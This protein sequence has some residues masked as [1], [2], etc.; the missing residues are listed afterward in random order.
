MPTSTNN[1]NPLSYELSDNDIE[2][3]LK[4]AQAGVVAAEDLADVS[5]ASGVR[6]LDGLGNN[7]ENPLWGNADQTFKRLSDTHFDNGVDTPRDGPVPRDISNLILNQNKDGETNNFGPNAGEDDLNLE[8]NFRANEFVWAFGQYFDHGLDFI[9]KGGENGDGTEAGTMFL[10]NF[11]TPGGDIPLTLTRATPAD[12][13]GINGVPREYINQTSP[14]ID[15]NQ[16]YGSN[17]KILEFLLERDDNGQFTGRLLSGE[18]SDIPTLGEAKANWQ[19]GVDNGLAEAIDFS[20][21]DAISNFRGSG[22]ALL[23]DINPGIPL[24][25]HLVAGDGRVN[26]NAG[27]SVVHTIWHNNHNFWVEKLAKHYDENGGGE[28]VTNE[29]LY[30]MAK[31]INE[32]EYQ[33]A[34]ADEF[35]ELLVGSDVHAFLDYNPEINADITLEFSQAAYRLG[36]SMLNNHITVRTDADGSTED[37]PL[38]DLFLNPLQFTQLGADNIA[39]GMFT[40]LQQEI[41]AQIVTT[42]RDNLLGRPLD[43]A[44]LNIGR[45]RDTG[46]PTLNDMRE[47]VGLSKYSDWD[48]F[49][50][51][52]RD[53]SQIDDFKAAYNSIDE[54]DLWVGGLA[55]KP[56]SSDAFGTE[57]AQ[58]SVMGETFAQ[59]FSTQMIALQDGDRFYYKHR[60]L[61]TELLANIQNQ[62]FADIIERTLDLEYLSADVFKV[63][64]NRLDFRDVDESQE[65]LSG[66]GKL[67]LENG[68]FE[69]EILDDGKKEGDV[70]GWESDD[71]YVFNPKDSHIDETSLTGSNMVYLKDKGWISQTLEEEYAIG[72]DYSFDVDLGSKSDDVTDDRGYVIKL[73]AGD[74]EIGRTEGSIAGINTLETVS[75]TSQG[76]NNPDL[77]GESIRIV[78]ENTGEEDLYIDNVRGS[79]GD[80]GSSKKGHDIIIG[81]DI[82]ETIFGK[83]GDDTIFAE[84]GDDEVFGGDGDDAMHGGAGDD[85]LIGEDG[86]DRADG[87]YGNDHIEGGIGDDDLSG[88]EG[89]DFV[90]GGLNDDEAFGGAGNDHVR[91]GSG[92]DE[93][94]G[95]LGDDLVDA[96]VGNDIANGSDGNDTVLGGHGNDRLMGGEG[97]DTLTGGQ[98][99]DEYWFLPESGQDVITDF[100]IGK[101]KVDLHRYVWE[102]GKNEVLTA[103]H[104]MSDNGDH[105][106]LTLPED[107]TIKFEGVSKWDLLDDARHFVLEDRVFER[108]NLILDEETSIVVDAGKSKD[109]ARDLQ[110]EYFQLAGRT[111]SLEEIDFNAD[112]IHVENTDEV[113]FNAK[114]GAFYQDGPNDYF[115]ARMTS[116]FEAKEAGEYTFHLTSDDGSKLIINEEPVIDNDGLHS[117]KKETVTIELEE[118]M[119]ELEL[120]YF[121]NTGNASVDLD[122]SGPGFGKEQ[123]K[124]V[125]DEEPEE[126]HRGPVEKPEG[127]G[128]EIEGT[129][130][131]DYLVGTDGNDTINAKGGTDVVV[132]SLGDDEIDGGGSEYDQVDYSGSASDHTFTAN[133][134]GSVTVAHPTNG[135]DTLK[136]V[137]GFWFTGEGKWYPIEDL[138]DPVPTD[139]EGE[140]IEGTNGNDYLFGT[141]GNDTIDAKGGKDVVNGSLGNDEIDGGGSEYDQV[142]YSGAASDYTFTANDDG[143]VTVVHPTNGTDTLKNIDGFWF[144]GEGKWYPLE[145]L[146]GDQPGGGQ[147]ET[148]EGTDDDDYLVGTSGDDDI[149][150]KDGR[151][152]IRGSKGDDNIDGGG[153]EYD[154]VDYS[155]AAEDYTFTANDDGSVTS[156]HD[157]NGT[158]TLKNIDGFWFSGEGKWYAIDDVVDLVPTD[159]EGEEINGTNKADFLAGTNGNDEINGRGGRDVIK[160]SLGNDIIDGGG[161]EY[162]Q[163]DYKG[164]K[165]D[166]VFEAQNNGSITVSNDVYGVDTLIDIDGVWFEGDAEWH[167]IDE[168]V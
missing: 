91:G 57:L 109:A 156:A 83:S 42:V 116:N 87:G 79:I 24:D 74:T 162:D 115:A 155:G 60:L 26:E 65:V 118:G 121:E 64:D 126:P 95:G 4:Q 75:I 32:A 104:D 168:L 13:T 146:I 7:V 47:S 86:D 15:Q 34:V 51:N 107:S 150:G 144:T 157:T 53:P 22:D 31:I 25:A 129:D 61:E 89:E 113:K 108:E 127:V 78:I 21:P 70:A 164:G 135:T 67:E 143:S 97:D 159:I 84:G 102:F 130:G 58:N 38:F 94:W 12:G 166:Y 40:S 81:R 43:L 106:L 147:G 29:H 158:D 137:D 68:S 54:V 5:D 82:S 140:D 39:S 88:N 152:V 76:S 122:W 141:A 131:N 37:V 18:N 33:R 96:G 56:S 98:G 112:P 9:P 27:L 45:G 160:N 85:R 8:N 100:E 28:N 49:A 101:D 11:E 103:L 46:L 153:S 134:D 111:E 105:T 133:T 62:D 63:M 71:A 149:D 167:D 161:S 35:I 148:I 69:E 14:F 10:G 120:L 93:L 136:D 17:D 3:L 99:R 114:G 151:D 1:S 124:F 20:D 125:A 128:E 142:D 139:I 66:T 73:F 41:D 117:S 154:Q 52:L 55:E 16:A 163:V 44:S 145:D 19:K 48:S 23:L 119:H 138:V 6:T 30:Q 59:V 36:H 132:G 110:I 2:F 123:M 90:D 92:H 165:D 50:N 80:T 72:H 77:V